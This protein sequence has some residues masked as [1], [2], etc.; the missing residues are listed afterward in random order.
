MWWFSRWVV[1][2]SCN[3]M[4]CSPPG[5]SV[6]GIFQAR[7]LECIAIS[8][9]RVSSQPR[10]WTQVSCIHGRFFTDWAT[11]NH[12]VKEWRLRNDDYIMLSEKWI[13]SYNQYNPKF[14]KT[15]K[16]EREKIQKYWIYF[17]FLAAPHG[18]QDLISWSGIEPL[19]SGSGS[20]DGQGISKTTRF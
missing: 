7:L 1:S 4:N 8:F 9:S 10:N 15:I 13:N 19:P 16:I 5:S 2:D 6:H 18:M 3:P 12:S 14:Y 11:N 20:T 17:I